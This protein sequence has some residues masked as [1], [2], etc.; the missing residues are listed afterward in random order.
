[1]CT[2][3]RGTMRRY[4]HQL[5][6]IT[7]SKR[8][9]RREEGTFEVYQAAILCGR[10]GSSRYSVTF[11]GCTKIRGITHK[12]QVKHGVNKENTNRKDTQGCDWQ[13]YA[14]ACTVTFV[15]LWVALF[16]ILSKFSK[17]TNLQSVAVSPQEPNHHRNSYTTHIATRPS[18]LFQGLPPG[19]YDDLSLRVCLPTKNELLP[20]L[21]Q[22]A[23]RA[24]QLWDLFVS[25]RARS[26][27]IPLVIAARI[28]DRPINNL[29]PKEMND[30]LHESK[31]GVTLQKCNKWVDHSIDGSD[32]YA[33]GR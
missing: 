28:F 2:K 20:F 6:K 9:K 10:T 29:G 32:R 16:A 33:K 4:D 7:S 12:R 17:E 8:Q 14:L 5:F 19:N 26:G 25:S 22:N 27:E 15:K 18:P 31:Q 21:D 24:E 13:L 23:S 11:S 30:L 1:M 3:A